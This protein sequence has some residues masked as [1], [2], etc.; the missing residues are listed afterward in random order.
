MTCF[1]FQNPSQSA[2][3]IRETSEHHAFQSYTNLNR[4]GKKYLTKNKVRKND[5][6]EEIDLFKSNTETHFDRR[7]EKQKFVFFNTKSTHRIL[8]FI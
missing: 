4:Q 6:L 7:K 1:Y 2:K 3:S 8:M 5:V